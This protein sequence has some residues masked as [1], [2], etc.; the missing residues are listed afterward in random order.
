L[1]KDYGIFNG[2]RIV[3][4]SYVSEATSPE[5][6]KNADGTAC[7]QYAYQWWLLNYKGKQIPYM[8]GILGQFVFVLRDENAVVV[9]L[10]HKRN[11]TLTPEGY[12]I[13]A[14]L[15]LDAA[16]SILN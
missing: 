11:K 5:G 8:R 14:K 13:D 10:G 4:S 15:Y 6:L 16:Y 12:P 1:Y 3:D 9:R 7:K 2:K